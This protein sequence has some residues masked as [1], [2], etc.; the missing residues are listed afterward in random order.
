MVWSTSLRFSVTSSRRPATPQTTD[1]SQSQVRGQKLHSAVRIISGS[2]VQLPLGGLGLASPLFLEP[3]GPAVRAGAAEAVDILG[4]FDGS[5]LVAP[6]NQHLGEGQVV[7]AERTADEEFGGS[8]SVQQQSGCCW[9]RTA[10]QT[11]SRAP[12]ESESW[13]RARCQ[14]GGWADSPCLA[15]DVFAWSRS[16]YTFD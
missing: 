16:V 1:L 7:V 4:S 5:Y 15:H 6:V 13:A 10:I 11:Q 2:H 14:R 9:D 3:E 12:A 8:P